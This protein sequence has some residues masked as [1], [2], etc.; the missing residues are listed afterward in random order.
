MERRRTLRTALG[1]A[2]IASAAFYLVAEAIAVAAC[3]TPQNAY[4]AH[5]ISELG[6]PYD[7]DEGGGFSPLYNLMNLALIASGAAYIPCYCLC[8]NN[9]D[10]RIKRV[11]CRISAALTGLGIITVGIFHGGNPAVL[12]VHGA[13][14]AACFIFG[15]ALAVYTGIYYKGEGFAPF[16][17]AAKIIGGF[18]LAGAALTFAFS[19]SSLARFAGIPE[20]LAVY[21]IILWLFLTGIYTIR[22]QKRGTYAALNKINSL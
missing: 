9:F 21:S 7:Y 19:F 13:G 1:A 20:R 5:T 16:A 22:V 4:F 18:G 15:N 10:N 6:I 12:G 17:K 2:C 3:S 14:A 11:I 8:F